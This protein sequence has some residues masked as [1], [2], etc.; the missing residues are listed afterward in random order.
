MKIPKL[1]SDIENGLKIWKKE[2]TTEATE[3]VRKQLDSKIQQ[4]EAEVAYWKIKAETLAEVC[5]RISVE[6]MDMNTRIESIETNGAKKKA[7]LTGIKLNSP[8]D[9]EM[10]IAALDDF[11]KLSKYQSILMIFFC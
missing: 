4:M 3:A 2:C 9:K 11:P 5:D 6:V 8:K 1:R 7:L 10:C